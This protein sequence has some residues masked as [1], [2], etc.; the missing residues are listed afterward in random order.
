MFSY[1]YGET[2]LY[3]KVNED[4]VLDMDFDNDGEDEQYEYSAF[5]WGTINHPISLDGINYI[6]LLSYEIATNNY[7]LTTFKV[8]NNEKTVILNHLISF[9]EKFIIERNGDE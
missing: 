4:I 7:F 1:K 3:D 6:S 8:E 5:F 2:L 9:D